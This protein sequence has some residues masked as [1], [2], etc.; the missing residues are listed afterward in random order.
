MS[1]RA[2]EVALWIISWDEIQFLL[3]TLCS[4]VFNFLTCTQPFVLNIIFCI[5]NYRLL[6]SRSTDKFRLSVCLSTSFAIHNP[7]MP[8][9]I[10]I[11]YDLFNLQLFI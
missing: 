3:F 4:N 1:L 6:L 10:Y 9:I 8:T 11:H 5:T 7:Y 2:T